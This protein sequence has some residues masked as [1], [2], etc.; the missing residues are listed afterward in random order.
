MRFLLTDMFYKNEGVYLLLVDILYML[1]Y[2]M[3]NLK[4]WGK[5]TLI[6]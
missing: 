6:I 1:I 4:K 2:I 3:I 5:A